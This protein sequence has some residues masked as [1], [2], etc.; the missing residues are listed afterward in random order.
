LGV[1]RL[2]VKSISLA[3]KVAEVRGVGDWY[4]VI[5]P[6]LFED[7]PFVLNI[8]FCFPFWFVDFMF[9]L[10]PVSGCLPPSC[11]GLCVPRM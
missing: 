9:P 1:N 5:I 3:F 4:D 6:F 10:S 8:V 7:L 2:P 11:I